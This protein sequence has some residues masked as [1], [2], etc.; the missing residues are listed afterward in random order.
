MNTFYS[1]YAHKFMI[2][3]TALFVTGKAV[4][5]GYLLVLGHLARLDQK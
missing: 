4:M 2:F 3:N 5:R 1:L